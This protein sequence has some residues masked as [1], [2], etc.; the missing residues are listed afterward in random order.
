MLVCTTVSVTLVDAAGRS[1]WNIVRN[2]REVVG[3]HINGHVSTRTMA[4]EDEAGGLFD[5]AV[6]EMK[7]RYPG[8]TEY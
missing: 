2:G 6:A 1:V 4:T 8:L 7:R 3:R 5:W